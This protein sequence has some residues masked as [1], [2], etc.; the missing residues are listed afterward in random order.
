MPKQ[1][2][3]KR[4]FKGPAEFFRLTWYAISRFGRF[5]RLTSR[6]VMTLQ[7]RE[8]LMLAVTGVNRCRA[9]PA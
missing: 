7:F 1:K 9:R 6:G 2:F 3:L 5:V 4:T 8:Q